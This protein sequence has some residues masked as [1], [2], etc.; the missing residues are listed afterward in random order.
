[1]VNHGLSHRRA[2]PDRG[3]RST[4][5]GTRRRSPQ[6]GGL[7]HVMPVYATFTLVIFLA[8]MGLPLLNG[9]IG[10]F[11][12]LQGAFAA[13]RGLGLL[14]GLRRR[15]GRGLP[16]LALPAR[17]LGQDHARGERA[18]R[19]PE[20][21]RARDPR[22]AGRPLLLD[23]HLPEAVPRLPA[24]AGPALAAL[25]QPDKFQPRGCMPPRPPP[26]PPRPP[27]CTTSR[28]SRSGVRARPGTAR[29]RCARAGSGCGRRSCGRAAAGPPSPSSPR[30]R[31]PRRSPCWRAPRGPRAAPRAR[32]S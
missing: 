32:G 14:G 12:I 20:R 19:G 9:F 3:P 21:P 15:A 17:L 30:S 16:A 26:P 1:M 2:L 24:Q 25:V 13:N 6:F 29:A 28:W 23:R 18:P 22:A 5:G 11:M 8:S 7:A 27:P 10:E 4:S 31:G